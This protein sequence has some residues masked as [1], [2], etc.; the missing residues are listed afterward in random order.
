MSSEGDHKI[1]NQTDMKNLHIYI[2]KN[3]SRY[4]GYDVIGSSD[5]KEYTLTDVAT[6]VQDAF[7][8]NVFLDSTINPNTM[9][10]VVPDNWDNLLPKEADVL[11]NRFEIVPFVFF[12]HPGIT[13]RQ[14]QVARAPADAAVK[15]EFLKMTRNGQMPV[16]QNKISVPASSPD[17]IQRLLNQYGIPSMNT[18]TL[19][20]QAPNMDPVADRGRSKT[21]EPAKT[22]ETSKTR[23]SDMPERQVRELSKT[24]VPSKTRTPETNMAM[25]P[26]PMTRQPSKSNVWDEMPQKSATNDAWAMPRR[27]NIDKSSRRDW[28]TSGKPSWQGQMETMAGMSYDDARASLGLSQDESLDYQQA[29]HAIK[30][31]SV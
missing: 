4:F 22:R 17:A 31:R 12:L 1:T 18:L 7:G 29:W 14:L 19:R 21:R 16:P 8:G 27:Q 25:P 26:P 5:L 20:A 6:K 2:L 13:K 3:N 23:V 11:L 10:V 9:C 30:E 15:F 28:S 24:R